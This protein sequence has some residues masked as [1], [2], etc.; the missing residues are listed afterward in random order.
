MSFR[1]T[2][3][4][5]AH[6]FVATCIRGKEMS[7]QCASTAR[8]RRWPRTSSSTRSSRTLSVVKVS[9]SIYSQFSPVFVIIQSNIIGFRYITSLVYDFTF[10]LTRQHWAWCNYLVSFDY[11]KK[12]KI[13]QLLFS[14]SDG[15]GCQCGEK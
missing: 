15:R 5:S 10:I 11:L 1:I 13:K 6:A 14:C 9:S 3:A 8:R 7:K 12:K 4:S 2:W